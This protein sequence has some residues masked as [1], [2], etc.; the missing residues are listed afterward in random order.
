ML[1][2]TGNALGFFTG[3]GKVIPFTDDLSDIC[4]SFRVKSNNKNQIF[5]GHDVLFI[6]EVHNVF[7]GNSVFEI[8][9]T[10]WYKIIF[11][12]QN[13]LNCKLWRIIRRNLGVMVAAIRFLQMEKLFT[14]DKVE[15]WNLIIRRFW[16]EPSPLVGCVRSWRKGVAVAATIF[17]EWFFRV[18]SCCFYIILTDLYLLYMDN[19]SF[20]GRNYNVFLIWEVFPFFG[21]WCKF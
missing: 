17:K 15:H 6:N 19:F 18:A 9:A 7:E 10:I 11:W 20:F 16:W 2:V 14:F 12:T 21:T 13:R 1:I 5:T 4:R 3:S 8:L